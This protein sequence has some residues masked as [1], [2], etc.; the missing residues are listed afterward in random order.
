VSRGLTTTVANMIVLGLV[1]MGTAPALA[2][3]YHDYH[4][5][6]RPNNSRVVNYH[7]GYSGA[8]LSHE[9]YYAHPVR[10]KREPR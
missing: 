3:N 8:V 7:P 4:P 9:Y 2:A 10:D 1:A 5:W 6:S